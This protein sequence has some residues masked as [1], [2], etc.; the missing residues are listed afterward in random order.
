MPRSS[1][2]APGPE[3]ERKETVA[4]SAGEQDSL[5]VYLREIA[6]L[7]PLPTEREKE[8]GQRIR[9]GDG[10]ALNELVEANLRFVVAYAKRYRGLGVS[11]IDLIHEGN[12]GL[13]EAAR[14]FDPDRNVR[15]IS[16]AVWWIRQSILL[17]LSEQRRAFRMPQRVVGR[18]ARV[19]GVR[20]ALR[21][22]LD[23]EPTMAEVALGAEMTEEE[24]GELDQI[25]AGDVSLSTALDADGDLELE[26]VLEQ[27]GVPGVET[28]LI[29]TSMAAKLQELVKSL[30]EK[31]REVIV[32]RFG[33]DG[34]DPRTLQEIGDRL[35]VTRERV[36][37]IESRAKEKLR[38]MQ[39]T[40]GLRGCLN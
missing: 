22:E 37:Q 26:D 40:Q 35:G 2:K 18:V 19:Q 7:H 25:N 12:L 34:D 14:R 39:P 31:E 20:D 8:L 28:E 5:R 3:R 38:R 9:E 11:L 30:D 13:I 6:S 15:F 1:R 16:Y 36:R 29:R 32:M 4:P 17:A 33:L 10:A 23:R 21:H 24:V 27:E